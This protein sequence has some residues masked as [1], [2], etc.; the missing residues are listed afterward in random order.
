MTNN[1]RH[2]EI[3]R[4][5]EIEGLSIPEIAKRVGLCM[6]FVQKTLSGYVPL[7]TRDPRRCPTCGGLYETET[8]LLCGHRA[9]IIRERIC[10]A[11]RDQECD[12]T[13]EE[14]AERCAEVQA[15]WP[16]GEAELRRLGTRG[17]RVSREDLLR[18]EIPVVQFDRHCNGHVMGG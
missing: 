7:P 12:P 2:N 6:G 8:C 17:A 5:R 9:G 16:P 15:G 13:P 3:I 11:S 1:S 14:I 4:L 10:G 18:Y